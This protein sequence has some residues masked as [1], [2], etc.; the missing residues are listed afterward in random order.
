MI[1]LQLPGTANITAASFNNSGAIDVDN[2]FNATS[3]GTFIQSSWFAIR[4][5]AIGY[6]NIYTTSI[7]LFNGTI[8][9]FKTF[10]WN[11]AIRVIDIASSL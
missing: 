4:S 6:C 9:C 7:V 3:T 5:T 1:A 10:S 11:E 2:S 8:T